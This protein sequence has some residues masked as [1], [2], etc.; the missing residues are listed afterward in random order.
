MKKVLYI[1]SR[2]GLAEPLGRSQIL[3][4]MLELSKNN[5]I[6]IISSEKRIDLENELNIKKIKSLL[7][8][9]N[10]IWHYSNFKY[11][12]KSVPITILNHVLIA[13]FFC[14]KY[15]I[16]IIH[17]RSYIS[18]YVGIIIKTLFS[19][20]LIFDMRAL[21]PEEIALGLKKGK[22][23]FIYKILKI[24]EIISISYSNKIVSLTSRARDYLIELYRVNPKYIYTI[25]TCV[26]IQRFQYSK[27]IISQKKIFSCVGTI[28]SDWF[29]IDHLSLFFRCVEKF[30]KNAI[31]EIIS[32]DNKEELLIRLNLNSSLQNKLKIRSATPNEMPSLIKYHSASSFFFK[33]D[34]SKLGS[35]PTRFGEILAV[36]RPVICNSG[37]GDLDK[38]V[39]DNGVG[40]VVEDSKYSSMMEGVKKLYRMIEDPITSKKC[41]ELAEN[42][43]SLLSGVKKYSEIYESEI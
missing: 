8:K 4:Y 33:S 7:K 16:D 27:P 22:K 12:K 26:D 18:N 32:N 43:Y 6:Y 36:G 13:M 23:S 24:S 25:P 37:V 30:D 34:L 21:W 5:K 3:P 42:Y 19:N 39:I 9:N 2:T 38:L 31:F 28:L 17:C 11:G 40:I 35:S 29:L 10:I 41:R 1:S 14:M 20:Q 15:K